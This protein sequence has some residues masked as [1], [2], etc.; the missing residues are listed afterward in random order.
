MDSATQMSIESSLAELDAATERLLTSA[1]ALTDA[2]V[3][4]PSRLPG[5]SR[6]HLLTHL[7]RN[8]D[9]LRELA[10]TA[11]DGQEREM[12]PGGREGRAA[13]IEAGAGRPVADL[14]ADIETSADRLRAAILTI[15]EPGL[16]HEFALASGM[17]FRGWE[18]PLVRLREVELHH[19]DLGVGYSAADWPDPFVTRTL[20][21]VAPFFRDHREMPVATM[22][23][24]DTG[25][26][27]Q[28]GTGDGTV[29][30]TAAALAAW[31]LG[32]SDRPAGLTWDGEG[33][34][35]T[36]PAFS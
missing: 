27:W 29:T 35:P 5:W 22:A 32:R 13:A 16:R 14:V 11:T 23:D 25:R 20:D 24:P 15:P 36:P 1:R 8:S 7:A 10:R 6:G 2:T 30:G 4:A 31:L 3:R 28:V 17:R 19:V 12:Y 34:V 9:A 26:R 21:Q 33:P 18:I